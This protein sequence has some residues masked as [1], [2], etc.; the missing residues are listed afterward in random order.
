MTQKSGYYRNTRDI[1]TKKERNEVDEKT[2][3][4]EGGIDNR[5]WVEET[6]EE[7]VNRPI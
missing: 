1:T 3:E 7:W 4:E 6:T 2:K 5:R